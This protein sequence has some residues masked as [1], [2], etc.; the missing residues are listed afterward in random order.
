M[1][2]GLPLL[3]IGLVITFTEGMRLDRRRFVVTTTSGLVVSS[4]QP[5]TASD[6]TYM[7]ALSSAQTEAYGKPK[8]KYPDFVTSPSGLQYKDA[9]IGSGP[10]AEASDRV[11]L[12][13][14]G[15]TIGYY[16]RPFEKT[17]GPKGSAFDQDQ[18][19][20][21]FVIGKHTVIPALEEGMVGM[22]VGGVRQFVIPPELGYPE[23]DRGHDR[24]GPKPSTFSGQRALD[25]VLTNQG[26]IDKT[27]LINAELKRIDKVGDRGFKG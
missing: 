7:P 22:Q 23:S 11:V 21:R 16:G 2:G 27:I 26:M 3:A 10:R 8:L 18:D 20:Y 15:Y 1:K 19:Y 14:E 13:W 24:V 17:G 6:K 12:S 9:K 25:F 4:Q 5:A